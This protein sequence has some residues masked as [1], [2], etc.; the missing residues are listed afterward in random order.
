[1]KFH[2]FYMTSAIFSK[3]QIFFLGMENAFLNSMT[4]LD[5]INPG[6]SALKEGS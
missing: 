2:D 3:T 1:M 4:F 6:M 5:P